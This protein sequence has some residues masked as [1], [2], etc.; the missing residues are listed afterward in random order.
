ME[1]SKKEVEIT[2]HSNMSYAERLLLKKHRR[3]EVD[4]LY[5]PRDGDPEQNGGSFHD[6][7]YI[8]RSI[9]P[10]IHPPSMPPTPRNDPWLHEPSTP[11]VEALFPSHDTMDSQEFKGGL[12]AKGKSNTY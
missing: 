7:D 2:F 3:T 4:K 12:S 1:E 11:R 10:R 9:T 8:P 5:T 6:E